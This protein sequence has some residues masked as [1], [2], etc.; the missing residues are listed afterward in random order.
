MSKIS[1]AARIPGVCTLLSEKTK[2]ELDPEFCTKMSDL[3]SEEMRVV[4]ENE[5]TAS[6]VYEVLDGMVSPENITVDEETKAVTLKVSKPD[7]KLSN[8]LRLLEQF[9][10]YKMEDSIC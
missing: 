5:D 9:L 3:I 10:Q 8:R 6:F 1:S 7:A 2:G 4:T